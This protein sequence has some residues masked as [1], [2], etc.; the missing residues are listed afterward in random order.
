MAK[1]IDKERI[2]ELLENGMS[3]AS[4]AQ[5]VGCSAPWVYQVG[6]ERG[7]KFKGLSVMPEHGDEVLALVRG[8]ETFNAVAKR[9][10]CSK[11]AVADYCHKHGVR[12]RWEDHNQWGE[13]DERLRRAV[14]VIEKHTP[15]FEYVGGFTDTDSPIDLRYKVCG[16]VKRVS[17]IMV[18]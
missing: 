16:T 14:N 10:G 9:F 7:Y 12:S 6:R 4:V 18:R 2:V 5:A 8:G 13:Y 17:M 3:V 15:M 1:A 11:H